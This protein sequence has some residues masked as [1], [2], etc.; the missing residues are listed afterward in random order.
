MCNLAVNGYQRASTLTFELIE[1]LGFAAQ[2]VNTLADQ[3][4]TLELPSI[5]LTCAALPSPL[6]KSEPIMSQD[7]VNAAVQ[8]GANFRCENKPSRG[9]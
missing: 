5:N 7:A 9:H 8:V 6:L 1:D 2:R 4:S 3:I